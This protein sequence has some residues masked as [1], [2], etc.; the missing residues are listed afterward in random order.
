MKTYK[1]SREFPKKKFNEFKIY[2]I[3][4]DLFWDY[5]IDED[6][7]RYA[8]I[9][10]HHWL[11]CNSDKWYEEILLLCKEITDR[12]KRIDEINKKDN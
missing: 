3:T 12:I 6:W 1:V 8:Q 9:D 2:R 10:F 7:I 5:S 11:Q 4:R